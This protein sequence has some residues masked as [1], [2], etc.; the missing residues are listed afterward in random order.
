MVIFL[1][2]SEVGSQLDI[3][4]LF[5]AESAMSRGQLELSGISSGLILKQESPSIDDGIVWAI[6][7]EVVPSIDV[8]VVTLVDVEVILSIGVAVLVSIVSEVPMSIDSEVLLS[9]YTE[10]RSLVSASSTLLGSPNPCYLSLF[11]IMSVGVKTGHD[12]INA[13]KF[14]ENQLSIDP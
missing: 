9:I 7:S 4:M 5:C 2:P 8:E 10:V 13:G 11:A 14:L 3:S 12:G 1:S 6:D